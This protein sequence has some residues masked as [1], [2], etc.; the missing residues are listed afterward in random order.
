MTNPT[1]TFQTSNGQIEIGMTV[2]LPD[3]M[4]EAD[5]WSKIHAGE[6][7]EIGALKLNANNT[8]ASTPEVN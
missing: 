8:G 1:L 2:E 3:G 4:S 5:F 6:T 7:V